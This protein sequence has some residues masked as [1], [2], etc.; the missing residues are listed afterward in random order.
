MCEGLDLKVIAEGI[1]EEAQAD[2]LIAFGCRSGQGFLYGKPMAAE[3]ALAYLERQSI[4]RPSNVAPFR[5]A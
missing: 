4:E 3:E 1:E 5:R 2:R